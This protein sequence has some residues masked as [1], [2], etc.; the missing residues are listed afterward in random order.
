MLY[1]SQSV[2]ILY[3]KFQF[4][5]TRISMGDF[6]FSSDFPTC[7]RNNM[8]LMAPPYRLHCSQHIYHCAVQ[9]LP[10]GH[11]VPQRVEI[12]G[13]LHR[14]VYQLQQPV[15]GVHIG[16]QIHLGVSFC[17]HKPVWAVTANDGLSS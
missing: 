5:S 7:C 17:H 16:T 8:A 10:I 1:Q 3:I 15:R 11:N 13:V 9:P 14:Q 4:Y 6:H 12:S 2:F